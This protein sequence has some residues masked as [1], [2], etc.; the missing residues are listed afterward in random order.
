MKQIRNGVFETNS[1]SVHALAIRHYETE[2][3]STVPI[4]GYFGEYGWEYEKLSTPSDKLSYVLV[5]IACNVGLTY[6]EDFSDTHINKFLSSEKFIWLNE[7]VKKHTGSEIYFDLTEI[8]NNDYPFG[9][10]DHQ[11]IENGIADPLRDFWFE[12]KKQ[13]KKKMIDLIFNHKYYI[14]VDNDN[15]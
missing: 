12:D 6:C 8:H 15:N 11:S 1:S 3:L 2:V 14:I 9:Y 7:A 13:F 4:Q 10:I 5:A